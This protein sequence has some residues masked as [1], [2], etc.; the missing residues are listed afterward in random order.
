MSKREKLTDE[1]VELE[2]QRLTASEEV[3]LARK[4]QRLKYARRSYFFI[5]FS[6]PYIQV[7][8]RTRFQIPST[9]QISCGVLPRV[10]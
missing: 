9:P 10:R 1:Q 5:A 4:E 6:P 3:K 7:R 8:A 2:I